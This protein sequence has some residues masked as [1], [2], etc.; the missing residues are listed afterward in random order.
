MQGMQYAQP[1]SWK[2]QNKPT[3][4]IA[5]SVTAGEDKGLRQEVKL[6]R[7]MLARL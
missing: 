6:V 7:A 5:A 4:F 2:D 3:S 1:C